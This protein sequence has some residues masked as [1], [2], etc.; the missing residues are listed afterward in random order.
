M[1]R[2]KRQIAKSKNTMGIV[3][4]YNRTLVEKLFKSQDASDLLNLSERSHIWVK[5]LPI[6]V[7]DINNTKTSLLGIPPAVAI[8]MDRLKAKPSR[9]R[10][11]PMGFD[12]KRLPYYVNVRYLL[13]PEDM[14]GG[15]RRA[16]D[17]NW[18]TQIYHIHDTL[19][20]KNQPILYWLIDD[21]GISPKRSFIREELL[22]IPD[23][24]ELPPQ[25]VI[26]N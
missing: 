1:H 10:K 5:N 6:V 26:T 25:W 24:T 17:M 7:E 22:V 9:P 16:G 13:K 11:G 14:E 8:T 23:D 15:R 18:S 2:V 20:Q 12:E 21:N 19:V 3:E 4:R